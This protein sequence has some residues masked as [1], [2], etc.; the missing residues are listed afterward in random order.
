MF[1]D[2]E[3]TMH[4]AW[5]NAGNGPYSGIYVNAHPG[6]LGIEEVAAAQDAARGV[7]VNQEVTYG[8][9]EALTIDGRTAW[10]WAERLQTAERGLDWVAYRTVVSYDTVSYAIEFYSG[11]PATKLAAPDTL[12]AVIATFAIGETTW[13]IPLIAL[14]AGVLLIGFNTVRKKQ[15]EKAAHLRSINLVQVKKTKGAGE[16]EVDLS[17]EPGPPPEGGAPTRP[18]APPAAPTQ[19]RGG[20]GGSDPST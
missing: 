1:P 15:A 2:R 3:V 5:I 18:P 12:R 10:G 7:P 13:N 11:D 4:T 20:G 17:E 6:G 19:M 16:G 14:L 8:E 9:I